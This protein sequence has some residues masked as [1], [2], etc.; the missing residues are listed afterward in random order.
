MSGIVIDVI[1]HRGIKPSEMEKVLQRRYLVV[2][3]ML[4]D[5]SSAYVQP[6]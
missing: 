3:V 2:T 1:R 4:S 6:Q 5:L